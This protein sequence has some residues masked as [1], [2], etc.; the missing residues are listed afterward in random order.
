MKNTILILT[1][2]LI[3]PS[4]KQNNNPNNTKMS[5]L[6]SKNYVETMLNNIKHA[7]YEPMYYLTFSQNS[8]FSEIL[9]N[10]IPINKNFS[11]ESSGKT[12]PINNYI[13]KSGIQKVTFRL[14]P[15]GKFGTADFSTLVSDTEMNIEITESD[16]NKKQQEGKKTMSYTTPLTTT[17]NQYGNPMSEF[18]AT[19]KKYYEASFTFN[20]IV[21]Y[22]FESYSKGQDLRKYDPNTLDK[23]VVAFYK[24]QWEI[25]NSKKADDLFS[26][27]ELKEK[28]ISQSLFYNR[29]DL[30]ETL[31]AYLEPFTLDS[32]KLEP[33]ENYKLKFYGDGKIV[34]LELISLDSRLRGESALWGKYKE[35]GGTMATFRNYYLYIPEGKNELEI[36]R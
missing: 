22:E 27:L 12:L 33:L 1:A 13:F 17:I 16:N 32:Y 10:D 9:V 21:P 20:A 5:N 2:L 15:A 29:T 18:E 3:F 34:C 28:E 30:E 23:K 11:E 36:I 24:N 19:G 25:I 8:C 4:C 35:D 6:T 31:E 14:Y 7:N 26:F